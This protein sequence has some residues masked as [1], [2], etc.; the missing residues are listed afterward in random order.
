MSTKIQTSPTL[1]R[2][3]PAAVVPRP[4]AV[5]RGLFAFGGVL[6]AV[7]VW[8]GLIELDHLAAGRV[9]ASAQAGPGPIGPMTDAIRD[10]TIFTIGLA[11]VA[12]MTMLPFAL[13]VRRAPPWARV[14]MIVSCVALIAMIVALVSADAATLPIDGWFPVLH[15]VTAVLIL[16]AAIGGLVGLTGSDAAE[17][18]RRRQQVAANHPRLWSVSHLRTFEQARAAFAANGGR[19]SPLAA[20]LEVVTTP[21]ANHHQ[22][23]REV[24][25][26]AA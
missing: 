7:Y 23:A 1:V 16:A 2:G 10:F 14:A 5:T 8:L 4:V 22:P 17:Y 25:A 24:A 12:T 21:A 9:I 19:P 3:V 6:G 20:R 18:F 13:L 26:L 11:L 15:Y